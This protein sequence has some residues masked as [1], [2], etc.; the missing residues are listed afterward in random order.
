[1]IQSTLTFI[2]NKELSYLTEQITIAFQG[3]Q[4]AISKPGPY[5][6]LVW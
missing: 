4:W 3:F 1:M 2:V 6:G 5:L